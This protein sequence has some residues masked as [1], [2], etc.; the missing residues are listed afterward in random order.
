MKLREELP[1]PKRGSG[2]E[3]RNEAGKVSVG[4]KKRKRDQLD[5]SV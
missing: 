2:K 5:E 1:S 4:R 3:L